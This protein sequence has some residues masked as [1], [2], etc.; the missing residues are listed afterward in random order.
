MMPMPPLPVWFHEAV[1]SPV[2]V[3]LAVVHAARS[4][5]WKLATVEIGALVAYGFA[6]E[7]T[8]MMVFASHRYAAAWRGAPL[9]VPLAVAAVWGALILSGLA[10]AGRRGLHSPLARAALAAGLGIVLDLLMEPVA[11]RAGLWEWTPP[12]PWLG[13]PIGNFVGWTVIV[14]AYAFGAERWGGAASLGGQAM[15]RVALAAAAIVVLLVVGLAWRGLGAEELFRGAG[16]WVV[17]AALLIGTMVLGRGGAPS[18]LPGTSLASRL[19]T[20]SV[21]PRAVF[22]GVAA[23]FAFDAA[24]LRDPA[25]ALAGAGTLVALLVSLPDTWPVR[26]TAG[27][28]TASLAALGQ[29]EDLVRVLMKR[30]NG[31]PWTPEDR[32]F[33]REELRT[34]ARWAPALFLFL[35]PG[36]FILLPA[37]AW[38]LDRRRGLRPTSAGTG[39]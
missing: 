15:R 39:S 1:V 34:L 11:V 21:L 22:F 14:G 18:P 8:A 24:A 16:G 5:G 2:V 32:R 10:A 31:Q 6:L 13:V 4:L 36:S 28:R 9:G 12:G 19:G 25:L 38:L 17:W 20:R 23:T 7:K 29:V 35:L 27:W 37:Y 26:L 30:R 33:L 3:S